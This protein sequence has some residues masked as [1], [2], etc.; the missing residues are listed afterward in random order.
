[1][2]CDRYD[3]IILKVLSSVSLLINL[4]F[5]NDKYGKKRVFNI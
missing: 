1:M 5:D 4:N 2:S 3:F